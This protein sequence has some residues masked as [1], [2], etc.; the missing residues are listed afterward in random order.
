MRHFVSLLVTAL[1]IG[2][3]LPGIAQPERARNQHEIFTVNEFVH[4][5]DQGNWTDQDRNLIEI[6]STHSSRNQVSLGIKRGTVRFAKSSP[7]KGDLP[8]DFSYEAKTIDVVLRASS[9]EQKR[10]VRGSFVLTLPNVQRV[11]LELNYDLI[12]SSFDITNNANFYVE[13]YEPSSTS[14]TGW[15]KC[16]EFREKLTKMSRELN[17]LYTIE[18]QSS[19][20]NAETFTSHSFIANLSKWA[21]E[22]IMIVFVADT[23]KISREDLH[24]RWLQARLVG[25]TFDFRIVPINEEEGR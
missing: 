5:I 16:G 11:Q 2:S 10:E 25:C 22:E 23:A 3:S 21:G 15:S 13:I 17:Y 1:W 24:G 9:I 6:G 20:T 18:N 14:P 4:N 12:Q 19:G 7:M 8:Y